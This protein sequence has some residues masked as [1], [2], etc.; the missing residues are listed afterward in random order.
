MHDT[1]Q[2]TTIPCGW[3]RQKYAVKTGVMEHLQAQG[4]HLVMA[5]SKGNVQLPAVASSRSQVLHLNYK[6]LCFSD[7]SIKLQPKVAD[8]NWKP[9]SVS[10]GIQ[11]CMAL[12]SGLYCAHQ[13]CWFGIMT[14]VFLRFPA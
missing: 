7:R 10:L 9:C 12:W 6:Y 13:G 3:T 2:L 1:H 11:I 4:V 5:Q 8:N 14:Y